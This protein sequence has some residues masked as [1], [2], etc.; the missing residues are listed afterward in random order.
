MAE[1]FKLTRAALTPARTQIIGAQMFLHV[2]A[3]NNSDDN[4]DVQKGF[5][6]DATSKGNR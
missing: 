6:R 3:D 1:L 5:S 2:T 4:N